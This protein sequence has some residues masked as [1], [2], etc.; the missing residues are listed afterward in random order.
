MTPLRLSRST[1]WDL[2][3]L[4]VI[5]AL[6][7]APFLPVFGDYTGILAS[8][9]GIVAGLGAAV[10]TGSRRWGPTPTMVLA[11]V[12]H[13]LG[14]TLLL[15]AS[16]TPMLAARTA[17]MGTVTVWKDFL[18]VSPPVSAYDGMVLLPWM[19]SLLASLIAGRLLIAGRAI[20]AGIPTLMLL[21]CA[22]LWG[23]SA[24]SFA[25][26]VG[27]GVGGGTL[28]LWWRG[29]L[30]RESENLIGSV[31]E[32]VQVNRSTR[33]RTIMSVAALLVVAALIALPAAMTPT[34]AR[35]TLR[36]AVTPPLNLAEYATPL[37]LVR[38]FETD[39][40]STQL[41]RVD[42]TSEDMR[43]RIAT[44]DSY[45]GRNALIGEDSAQARFEL[46][47]PRS[48]LVK[49]EAQSSIT[50]TI[51]DYA[52]PWVPTIVST[53]SLS[54]ESQRGSLIGQGLYFDP[55]S[56]TLLLPA[57]TE[58]GDV[59]VEAA[60]VQ[61]AI[62]DAALASSSIADSPG[63]SVTN[64]PTTVSNLAAKI[65]GSESDPVRQVRA[66]Q[67]YLRLSYYSDG[68]QSPSLPGHSAVRLSAMA[69]A[70]VL[71]GDDEQYAVLMML[72]CH[73]L[74]IPARV[75]LGFVPSTDGDPGDITGEDVH[76]WVEIPFTG[77][78]WVPFDVT[79]DRDQI[80]QQQTTQKVSN[81]EPQVLQPPLPPPDSARLPPSYENEDDPQKDTEESPS[82]IAWVAAAII[83]SLVLLPLVLIIAAKALRRTRRRARSTRAARS[84][85]AWDEI[86]DRAQDF[87]HRATP[88]ATRREMAIQLDEAFP[89]ASLTAFGDA[90]DRCVFSDSEV[91]SYGDLWDSV[92]VILP[93]MSVG[94]PWWQR[95][96]ARLSL[97]S[98]LHPSG[99]RIRVHPRRKN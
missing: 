33:R 95:I 61:A 91:S 53:H 39:L 59:I 51:D 99:E 68:T 90:V 92:D 87:G 66:L 88:G 1:V 41:M 26:A 70:D 64:I 36:T 22:I 44:L 13:L 52:F 4:A 28:I 25:P 45:D 69:R 29:I 42:S 23:S 93:S 72:M 14:G 40:A 46:L 48:T 62:S 81:P 80:P 31:S 79:P 73:S 38:Y 2:L 57:G 15:L 67:Q 89:G 8:G 75:A 9:A 84:R 17:A 71:I 5:L 83:I 94:R 49:G 65:V 86:V 19:L 6:A 78:G 74:K 21:A 58:S 76:A 50:V 12:T 24:P 16:L 43:I 11:F 60:S 35:H 37:S 27:I 56:E 82:V 55:V 98:L 7:S 20:W 85:A 97:R 3:L 77:I 47:G 34:A 30:R 32:D 96:R 54:Y 63:G 10:L 18:T